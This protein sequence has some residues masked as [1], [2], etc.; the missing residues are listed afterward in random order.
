MK[1]QFIA[2]LFLRSDRKNKDGSNTIYIRL[3]QKNKKKDI[4]TKIKVFNKN[5]DKTKKRLK[6]RSFECQQKNLMLDA[7]EKKIYDIIL[8]A[9]LQNKELTL[10]DFILSFEGNNKHK[11]NN[12]VELCLQ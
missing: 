7:I 5:W 1:N 11:K 9:K 12:L 10:N 3:I 2:Y 6:C 4:S 8:T